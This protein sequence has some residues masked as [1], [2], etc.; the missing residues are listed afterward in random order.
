VPPEDA[1]RILADHAAGVIDLDHYR[2]RCAYPPLLQAAEI[3]ARRELAEPS[4]EALSFDSAIEEGHEATVVLTHADGRVATVRVV[5]ERAPGEAL[6]CAS[7]AE[8]QPW[9][10]RL[11]GFDVV[12]PAATS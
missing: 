9:H 12:E 8:S 7:L 6:T 3:F 1:A 5:R 2:G 11:L 10:H 4:L